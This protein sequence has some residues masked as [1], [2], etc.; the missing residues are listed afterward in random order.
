MLLNVMLDIRH[1]TSS[2]YHPQSQ[3]M[4][5]S[6]PKVLNQVARGLVEGHPE[7]W[8]MMPRFAECILRI[9]PMAVLGGR[10]PYEVVTGL[11]PRLPAKLVGLGPVVAVEVSEYVE[12]L[13]EYLR[14]AHASLM[15]RK[16]RW[17]RPRKGPLVDACRVSC[18]R[19]MRYWFG[20][21]RLKNARGL[22]DSS[23]ESTQGCI[24]PISYLW[25]A[26]CT[27]GASRFVYICGLVG[28]M[29]GPPATPCTRAGGPEARYAG[30]TASA[31]GA[32]KTGACTRGGLRGGG[33]GGGGAC[34]RLHAYVRHARPPRP[35]SL[36]F[37]R[38]PP[39]P[40]L[41]PTP[42]LLAC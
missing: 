18:G 10:C 36:P 12:R 20:G 22:S 17:S 16:L 7:D 39:P 29:H 26:A 42:T 31:V 24:G 9:S 14:G 28:C 11:R 35:R 21:S 8:E 1:V 19:G 30:A 15:R 3:G 32:H 23:S 6:M 38:P 13:R 5:E 25:L 4:L 34:G 40:P 2:T 37:S 41:S 33:G 27:A